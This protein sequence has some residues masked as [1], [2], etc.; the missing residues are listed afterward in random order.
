LGKL[1]NT[2]AMNNTGYFSFINF[3]F[4]CGFYFMPS[5]RVEV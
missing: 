3:Y 4:W 2:T 1:A 5:P